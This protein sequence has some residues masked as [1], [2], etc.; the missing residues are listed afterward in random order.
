MCFLTTPFR[1]APAQPP[2][3]PVLFDQSLICIYGDCNAILLVTSWNK[4]LPS[5]LLSR[6]VFSYIKKNGL[7]QYQTIK[8]ESFDFFFRIHFVRV[9]S[10]KEFHV[11][12]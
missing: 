7:F 3:P 8:K 5:V 2:P 11:I 9:L 10:N 12:E 4:I 6:Y 1:N